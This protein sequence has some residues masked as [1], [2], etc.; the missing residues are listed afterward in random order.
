ME[1]EGIKIIKLFTHHQTNSL[2]K[3]IKE[4]IS[5]NKTAE[6]RNSLKRMTQVITGK[7]KAEHAVL[8]RDVNT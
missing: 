4:A 1:W 2:N 6:F 3:Q 7:K 5:L 8:G